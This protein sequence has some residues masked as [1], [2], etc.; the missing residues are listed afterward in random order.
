MLQPGVTWIHVEK[1]V[2]DLVGVVLSSLKLTGLLFLIAVV[3]GCI[4]GV[5]LILHRRKLPP[6]SLLSPVSLPPDA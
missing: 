4:L 5:G 3:L 6:G 2:F 1:P